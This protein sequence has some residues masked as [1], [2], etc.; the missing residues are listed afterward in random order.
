MDAGLAGL[1]GGVIGAAVGALGA[2]GSA[3]ITGR[4][5]EQQARITAQ[6]QLTQAQWQLRLEYLNQRHDP[7]AQAYTAVLTHASWVMQLLE[8][9]LGCIEANDRTQF[10]AVVQQIEE[11][12]KDFAPLYTRVR[13]EGPDSMLYPTQVMEAVLTVFLWPME[14]FFDFEDWE[15]L[16][17][18][19]NKASGAVDQFAIAARKTLNDEALINLLS[20]T[21]EHPAAPPVTP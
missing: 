12:L 11:K 8:R 9:A 6:T 3:Y 13:V 18:Y 19:R 7:R 14:S 15:D 17:E 20:T 2:A 1:L 16:G 10:A 21:P 4:K 5:A